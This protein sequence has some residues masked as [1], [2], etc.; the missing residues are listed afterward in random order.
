MI[1][2]LLSILVSLIFPRLLAIILWIFTDWFNGVFETRLWPILGFIFLPT[3]ML[4]YSAVM[5]WYH[6]EWDAW[7]IAVL[8]IAILIDLSRNGYTVHKSRPQS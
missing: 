1:L 8:V 7:R 6:G 2:T 3:T 4:W 5:H